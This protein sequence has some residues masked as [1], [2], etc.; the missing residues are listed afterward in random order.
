MAQSAVFRTLK[1]AATWIVICWA[2]L[3]VE[4]LADI[5]LLKEASVSQIQGQVKESKQ[6]LGGIPVQLW[7][8]DGR[9]GKTS[10]IA[11]RDTDSS[12][13]FSFTTI[14]SGSYRLTFPLT[15]FGDDFLIHLKG[16]NLF[17]W[18]PSN[19][20]HVE[21]GIVSIH[22]PATHLEATRQKTKPS[23]TK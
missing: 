9:G 16:R 13:Y 12:G 8:T 23:G 21:L 22:C 14:P 2:I 3:P 17:R 6:T 11:E 19:W 7:A 20:L 5:C 1:K 18:F 4:S 10:L 15:G